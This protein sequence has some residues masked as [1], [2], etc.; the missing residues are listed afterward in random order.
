MRR[1]SISS[2]I[3]DQCPGVDRVRV[4]R[5]SGTFRSQELRMLVDTAVRRRGKRPDMCHS[6]PRAPNGR[7]SQLSP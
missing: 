3:R 1:A 7:V 5:P 6:Y 4:L 2:H